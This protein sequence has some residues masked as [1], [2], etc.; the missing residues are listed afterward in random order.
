MGLQSVI[1]GLPVPHPKPGVD[2]PHPRPAARAPQSLLVR[3]AEPGTRQVHAGGVSGPQRVHVNRGHCRSP[4]APPLSLKLLHAGVPPARGL[5]PALLG[6][7][8]GE[9][10]GPGVPC[11]T[12]SLEKVR[13]EKGVPVFDLIRILPALFSF[14]LEVSEVARFFHAVTASPAKGVSRRAEQAG[15]TEPCSCVSVLSHGILSF[16]SFRA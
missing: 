6:A 7:A 5:P 12:H 4:P 1:P 13:F 10:E 15:S 2:S 11:I 3:V 16:W 8:Q 9:E 14:P